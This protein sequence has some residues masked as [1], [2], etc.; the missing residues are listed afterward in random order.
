[1][2]LDRNSYAAILFGLI[3]YV[4]YEYYLNQ[5]YPD[6]YKIFKQPVAQVAETLKPDDSVPAR[7]DTL[8]T[9][10]QPK[11]QLSPS[12]Q[13]TYAVS[14]VDLEELRI[15]NDVAIYQFDQKFGSLAQVY[16][17]QHT[18]EDYESPLEL[19]NGPIS[20][21][22]FTSRH[23]KKIPVMKAPISTT[24]PNAKAMQFERHENSWVI[25]EIW[26][27]PEN[28]YGI[29]ITVEWENTSEKTNSLT[30]YVDFSEL[31]NFPNEGGF[32][33]FSMLS[34]S[35]ISPEMITY[36]KNES[37][38]RIDYRRYCEPDSSLDRILVHADTIDYLGTD[39][40]HFLKAVAPNLKKVSYQVDAFPT[41][42]NSSG[43]LAKCSLHQ[44]TSLQQG[45]IGPGKTVRINYSGWFGPKDSDAMKAFLPQLT[46]SLD[47]GMFSF[48]SRLFITMLRWIHEFIGDWGFAII[49][50]TI[51]IKVGLFPIQRF[52][53]EMGEKMKLIKPELDRLKEKYK[54]D[55]QR[56]SL[57]Q[58]ALFKKYNVNPAL[59][60]L[61]PLI[62][63][64]IFFSF[65]TLLRTS[66]DLRHASFLWIKDLSAAD[67][68]F[69]LPVVY[70]IVQ[71]LQQKTMPTGNMTPEMESIMKKMPLFFSL[72]MFFFPA[73]VVL[74]SVTNAIM[75]ILQ[76]YWLRR[77]SKS[78]NPDSGNPLRVNASK[79]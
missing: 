29:D 72:F 2:N 6:R 22:G 42:K 54:K 30:S 24:K 71:H 27:I 8:E 52:P 45:E 37:G 56:I 11:E 12:E 32:G 73:G 25:R 33:L 50:L 57:E 77:N 58:V 55:P 69:V 74:Y 48:I 31:A 65:F 51:F 19:L 36:A 46:E 23:D 18:S 20:L 49:L 47:L 5:K 66:I 14:S 61:A 7:E 1:M 40:S 26:Q 63:L 10:I 68:F 28:G 44:W 64:P 3:F 34:A 60:C 53:H 78:F 70:G 62:Q 41:G 15:E 39:S 16:L 9:T 13:E 4:G 21:R 35:N 17:K 67:P 43:K 75:T 38:N 59:G 79:G 76:Q